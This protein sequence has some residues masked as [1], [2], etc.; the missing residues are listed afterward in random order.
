MKFGDTFASLLHERSM[1]PAGF[2]KKGSTFSR[3]R[4]GYDEHYNIQ[5]SAWNSSS[6]A[7]RFYVNC[8]ISFPDIPVRSPDSGMWK[9]HAHTRLRT[10]VPVAPAEFDVTEQNQ[11]AALTQLSGLIES[12][13]DY[14]SRRHQIL[15]E[16][17]LTQHYHS[18]FPYD[19][20]LKRG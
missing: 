1:K 4:S 14:F 15:R 8:A 18:G 10:L 11:E 9:Y 12:C 16:S 2:K 5:G 6:G 7:W 13:A 19:P 17:Y 20:E 3:S